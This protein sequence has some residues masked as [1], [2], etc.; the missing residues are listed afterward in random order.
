MKWRAIGSKTAVLALTIGAL[1]ACSNDGTPASETSASEPATAAATTVSRPTLTASRLQPPSQD[2]DF[3]KAGGRPNVVV[4]PCTWVEDDVIS[5]LGFDPATRKRG[6]DIVG[7]YTFL[8]CDFRT[9]DRT[10]QLDSGNVALEEV[11]SKY[12]GKTQPVTI[13]GREAVITQKT[14]LDECS[15]DMRTKAGY[16]GLSFFVSTPGRVK[17]LKPC[18]GIVEAATALEPSIGKDN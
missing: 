12:A 17:G 4:D 1:G 13:N 16:L 3:T 5:R 14:N 7:E 2:N 11:K 8:T 6:N 18:D 15:L 10:L 9:S